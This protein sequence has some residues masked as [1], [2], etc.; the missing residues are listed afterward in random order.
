MLDSRLR[1]QLERH[2]QYSGKDEDIAHEIYAED[3]VLE[4]PQ[5]GERYEGI[6]NFREW[7]RRYPA[8]V[9]FKIR[10]LNRHGDLVVAELFISYDGGPPMYTVNLME[11]DSDD[12]VV[13]ERIY[14]MEGWAA[15]EWR[16]P[17]R[18]ATPADSVTWD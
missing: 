14:I 11:L 4:F 3:A 12:L 13:H 9:A 10:R 6:E 15:P 18:S 2:W 17:W 16:A 1:A 5:G 8:D 7:R